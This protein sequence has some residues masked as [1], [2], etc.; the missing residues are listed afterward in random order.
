MVAIVA[1]TQLWLSQVRQL[2]PQETPSPRAPTPPRGRTP[3]PQSLLSAVAE[4]KR[5]PA[6][7][8]PQTLLNAADPA[9][10]TPAKPRPPTPSG[11]GTPRA[12]RR[13]RPAADHTSSHR[14]LHPAVPD[15]L[16]PCTFLGTDHGECVPC[17]GS[18]SPRRRPDRSL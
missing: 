14:P 6:R 4:P 15:G 16:F 3:L 9:K 7:C 5:T 13:L 11:T 10:A 12:L 8:T 18:R 1:K 17:V 2:S